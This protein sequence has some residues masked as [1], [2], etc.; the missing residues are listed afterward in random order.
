MN[1]NGASETNSGPD[2]CRFLWRETRKNDAPAGVN[3]FKWTGKNDYVALCEPDYIS[4]GGG[5]GFFF[6]SLAT[7][8]HFEYLPLS[9]GKYGLFLDSTFFDG[10]SARCQ[11]FDNDVLCSTTNDRSVSTRTVR[12]ECVGME[13]WGVSR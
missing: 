3:V 11:T 6:C 13:V 1:L 7:L 8:I 9:D 12:F 2:I 10:S 4:F 5:C